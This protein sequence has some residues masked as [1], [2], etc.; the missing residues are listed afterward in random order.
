MDR[1]YKDTVVGLI[2]QTP[3]PFPDSFHLLWSW[4]LDENPKATPGLGC[5]K[6]PMHN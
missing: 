3:H 5:R 2:A 1:Y 4:N 6:S